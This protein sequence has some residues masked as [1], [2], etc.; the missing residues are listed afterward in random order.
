[1][2]SCAECPP[3]LVSLQHM[4]QMLSAPLPC[5]LDPSGPPTT[6]TFLAHQSHLSD[7][8]GDADFLGMLGGFLQGIPEQTYNYCFSKDSSFPRMP[9][10]AF[11]TPGSRTSGVQGGELTTNSSSR[12]LGLP[13][14]SPHRCAYLSPFTSRGQAQVHSLWGTLS[15]EQLFAKHL[16]RAQCQG[17]SG[18]QDEQNPTWRVWGDTAD[19]HM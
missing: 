14:R 12:G 2:L 16:L 13:S 7:Y 5:T 9:P 3:H 10:N 1:M 17:H 15:Q 11:S 8:L 19:G 18:Y 4:K 6:T